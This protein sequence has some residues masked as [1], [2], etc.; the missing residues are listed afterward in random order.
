MDSYHPCVIDHPKDGDH[1]RQ[2]YQMWGG[3]PEKV[4]SV[5][6]NLNV[7]TKKILEN[8]VQYW[9]KTHYFVQKCFR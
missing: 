4:Q 2:G 5:S 1:T 8:G 7:S 6:G 9:D 3:G